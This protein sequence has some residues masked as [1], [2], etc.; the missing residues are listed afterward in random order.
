MPVIFFDEAHKLPSLIQSSDTMKC[1]LDSML[2]LTKQDRLCHVVHATS[3][4]FYQTWLRQFNVAQHC[5]TLTIG[6][7]SRGEMRIYYRD[8]VQPRVPER[9]FRTLSFDEL[10]RAFG[11]KLAH[12]QDYITEFVN[13]SGAI[14]VKQSSHFLQA[15]AL[16][17]LHI[18]HSSQVAEAQEQAGQI[19]QGGP[20]RNPDNLH[21]NLGPAGFQTYPATGSSINSEDRFLAMVPGVYTADFEAMQLLKVLSRLAQ[22]GASYLPY[23]LVMDRSYQ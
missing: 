10:Y 5:K 12:W 1:L 13:S 8:Y 15:H 17:N 22:P 9:L 16:L 4:P 19:N 11:G 14:D 18:I 23:F 2:V 6:D 7:C 3:D 20:V 21:P